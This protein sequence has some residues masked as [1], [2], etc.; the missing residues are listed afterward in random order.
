MSRFRVLEKAEA[1][2]V[3]SV[4]HFADTQ[5]RVRAR[6][7]AMPNEAGWRY[8]SDASDLDNMIERMRGNGLAHWVADLPRSPETQTIES[9]L[10]Q[11][12]L[13]L[14]EYVGNLLPARWRAVK[15]W[16]IRAGNLGWAQR[17]LQEADVE[18]PQ[19]IDPVLE[20]LFSLPGDE[21]GKRLRQTPY[22]R[23]LSASSAFD[24]WL[25]D[26]DRARPS[27]SGREAYV[28]A[29]IVKE[30][31]RHRT[32]LLELRK[33]AT[34]SADPAAQWRLREQLARELRVLVGGDPFHAGLVLI[35]ALLE[36]LQYERCRALLIARAR[37]WERPALSGSPG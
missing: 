15:R 20:P 9:C 28:L 31:D 36:A 2:P 18:A 8:I 23:Y 22:H 29:R 35:Y 13:E 7:G 32:R 3:I 34:I 27:V 6:L 26:F 1:V 17:L 21:R 33:Q 19:R 11:H 24:R 16:L 37:G 5:A 12:L 10:L 4:F 25:S 30:V 14:L